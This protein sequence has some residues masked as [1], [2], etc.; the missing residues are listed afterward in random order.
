VAGGCPEG[1]D[2]GGGQEDLCCRRS[3]RTTLQGKDAIG[4]ELF[5]GWETN[6]KGY[7]APGKNSS[8]YS[9]ED[10]GQ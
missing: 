9:E 1:T 5:N 8:I 7:Y 2:A 4:F 10:R 3:G 6:I